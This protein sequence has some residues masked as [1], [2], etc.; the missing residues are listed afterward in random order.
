MS[1]DNGIA[2]AVGDGAWS[3]PALGGAAGDESLPHAIATAESTHTAASKSGSRATVLRRPISQAREV[4]SGGITPSI[5]RQGRLVRG[6][7]QG[8]RS[9]K[10]LVVVTKVHSLRIAHAYEI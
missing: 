8:D 4:M 2:L 5:G 1:N 3:I 10:R 6:P 9:Q 7:W